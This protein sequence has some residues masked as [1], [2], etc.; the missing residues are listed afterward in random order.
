[1]RELVEALL[2]S[3]LEFAPALVFASLGAVLSERAGVVN[4]GVEG[5]MRVG[6]FV[7]A[8]AA[9]S[10]P[11]PLGVIVGMI[12]GGAFAIIHA[13]LSIRWRADQVVSGMA[14]NIVALAGITFLLE[15]LFGP[16]ASPAIT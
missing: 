13:W 12:A 14:L 9:I 7:A 10:M 16:N 4:V 1:M 15:S 2:Y 8:V 3:T 6:A 11:T 5:M